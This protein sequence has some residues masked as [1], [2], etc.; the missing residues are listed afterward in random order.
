MLELSLI[1]AQPGNTERGNI[2]EAMELTVYNLDIADMCTTGRLN[3]LEFSFVVECP[4]E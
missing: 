1:E 3:D 2:L 4:P